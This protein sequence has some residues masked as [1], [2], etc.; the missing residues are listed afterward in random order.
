VDKVKGKYEE[1]KLDV[2]KKEIR[3]LLNE[4]TRVEITNLAKE[5]FAPNIGIAYSYARSFNLE[6]V[7]ER[8]YCTN[9]IRLNVQNNPEQNLSG[10]NSSYA[11]MQ[12]L[13]QI[14]G[15]QL[16]E[17]YIQNV[18]RISNVQASLKEYE[19]TSRLLTKYIGKDNDYL[20]NSFLKKTEIDKFLMRE[21]ILEEG[22]LQTKEKTFL[23]ILYWDLI[24][25]ITDFASHDYQTLRL[26][27]RETLQ[28][29]AY[30]MLE[31]TPDAYKFSLN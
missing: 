27:E 23:P 24:N 6:K 14:Q 10:I 22:R 21:E 2:Y 18:N 11:I 3:F 5:A 7:I 25:A 8:L 13:T 29:K 16:N 9:Q 20:L 1:I 26:E 15:P 4:N 28:H 12:S 17:Q 30:Q 31:Q 19:K